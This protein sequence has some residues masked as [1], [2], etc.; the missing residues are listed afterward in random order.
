MISLLFMNMDCNKT[1]DYECTPENTVRL[2][3]DVL[4][5]FCFKEGSYWIYKD[6]V[7]GVKDSFWIEKFYH[8]IDKVHK[9][10]WGNTKKCTEVFGYSLVSE[11]YGESRMSSV[12]NDLNIS[13]EKNS[14]RIMDVSEVIN[15]D[16]VYRTTLHG[17]SYDSINGSGAIQE[18]IDK[19][20]VYYGFYYN[21]LRIYYANPT[22]DYLLDTYYVRNIGL[23]KFKRKDGTIWE[24]VRY[25]IVQ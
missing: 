24:L 11:L 2:P 3:E 22:Y 20:T 1:E 18:I 14:Y 10:D 7:S 23:V 15:N 25:N 9:K 4:A 5:R 6:S 16:W 12:I 19:I 8:G 13:I 21:I 17:N